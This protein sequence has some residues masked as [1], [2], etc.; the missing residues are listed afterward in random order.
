MKNTITN[1]LLILAIAGL[2]GSALAQAPGA[3][4]PGHP[5]V[6]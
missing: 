2:T 1:S 6:R 5:R 3:Y 4:D